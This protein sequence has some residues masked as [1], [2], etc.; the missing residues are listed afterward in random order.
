MTTRRRGLFGSARRFLATALQLVQVRLRLLGSDVELGAQRLLDSI[1]LAM[2]AVISIAIGLVMVCALVLMV[3][4]ESHRPYAAGLLAL[5]LLG[6]GFGMIQLARAR[7]RESV[8]AFEATRAELAR[9]LD[10]L[11]SRAPGEPS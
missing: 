10:A 3:V 11:T 2:L 8:G 1:V 5:I 9:D 4:Q 6:A 7:I